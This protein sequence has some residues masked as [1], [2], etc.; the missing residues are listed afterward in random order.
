MVFS[1]K[2]LLY[3]V[4]FSFQI[5]RHIVIYLNCN[6]VVMGKKIG[7]CLKGAPKIFH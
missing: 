1:L 3:F 5:K 2:A 7:M 6:T 4:T